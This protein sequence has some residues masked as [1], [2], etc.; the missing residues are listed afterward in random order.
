MFPARQAGLHV[1]F[2]DDLA[3]YR[4]QKVRILNGTH[5][6]M[7]PVAYLHGLRTVKQSVEDE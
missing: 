7:V 3:P 5:T 6:A 2:A 1:T 4:T